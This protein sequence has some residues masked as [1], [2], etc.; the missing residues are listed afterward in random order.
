MSMKLG[1]RYICMEWGFQASERGLNLDAARTE[2]RKLMEDEVRKKDEKRA[3]F[4]E[5]KNE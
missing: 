1:D 4:E 2:F 3:A 5:K